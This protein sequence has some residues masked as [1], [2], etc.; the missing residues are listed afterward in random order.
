MVTW[1]HVP[2]TSCMIHCLFEYCVGLV[3]AYIEA[4]TEWDTLIDKKCHLNFFGSLNDFIC[5]SLKTSNLKKHWWTGSCNLKMFHHLSKS[6]TQLF[7]PAS[8]KWRAQRSETTVSIPFLLCIY[9]FWLSH[10][11][12]KCLANKPNYLLH[13]SVSFS[14]HYS[15]VNSSVL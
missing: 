14:P 3:V 9:W 12:S 10:S 8:D 7:Q 2:M 6:V 11:V 15:L 13:A 1:V 4:F 5:I